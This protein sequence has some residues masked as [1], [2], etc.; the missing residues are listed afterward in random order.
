[1][2]EIETT[3]GEFNLHEAAEE[4]I[5][6][7]S[8]STS[9]DD[10]ASLDGQA[11]E[12]ATEVSE[13]KELSP[14]DILKQVA[15]QKED[16]AQFAELLKGV[17]S[18]GMIRN[19]LPVNVDSPEQLKEL[20][21]KGFD[22]TQKTMEHAE[23]VKARE[24]EFQQK[25]SSFKEL[26]GQLAQK[27]QEIQQTIFTNQ[28]MGA[29]V[30]DLQAEDPELFAHLDALYRKKENAYMAQRPLQ[31]EFEGKI[32]ELEKKLSSFET[33]KQTE[34]LGK[35]KQGWE[36]ELS[37][38]QTKFAASISK[39]GVKPD[40]DKVKKAWTADA[41]NSMTVEQ[42]FY[43]VHGKDIVAANESYK[44]LLQTKTKTQE[45]L[46]GRTGVNGGQR[47]QEPTI[48]ASGLGD[49]SSILRQASATM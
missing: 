33:Q 24:A 16:P 25:E 36:S 48:E 37:D 47:G 18:L 4:I 10:S 11:D 32:S 15:E 2:E 14:E 43:A 8:Q 49:Y 45:K 29:I 9:T 21:Q 35:I 5:S 26:E 28:I 39:L 31:K 20:I 30:Q 7:D 42:A 23:A 34:E 27:E 1:M 22:Y 17:N 46:L 38:V 40:W 41:T 19:G 3:G 44:K 12:A 6:N 13:E